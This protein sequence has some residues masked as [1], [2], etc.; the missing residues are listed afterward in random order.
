METIDIL[1]IM[2]ESLRTKKVLWAPQRTHAGSSHHQQPATPPAA[3]T[4]ATTSHQ[5]ASTASQPAESPTT[6]SADC[7]S[8]YYRKCEIIDAT[9]YYFSTTSMR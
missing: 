1:I 6:V 2:V 3:T 7:T 9:S 4:R 8:K 5:P